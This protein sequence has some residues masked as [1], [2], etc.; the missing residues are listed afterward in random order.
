MVAED[1]RM[2]EE[3]RESRKGSHLENQATVMMTGD[4]AE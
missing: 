3:K 2:N 1:E 4:D